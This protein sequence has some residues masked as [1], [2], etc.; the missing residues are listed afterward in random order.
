MTRWIAGSLIREGEVQVGWSPDKG[1]YATWP[2]NEIF[3]P[4]LEMLLAE[5]DRQEGLRE[6]FKNLQKV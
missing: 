5:I 1:W 4:T 6:R 2:S 3:A